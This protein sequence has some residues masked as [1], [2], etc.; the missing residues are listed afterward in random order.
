MT[1]LILTQV[2]IYQLDVP[3]EKMEVGRFGNL[4]HQFHLRILKSVTFLAVNE[5]ITCG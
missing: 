5:N 1:C 4:L 2:V 3:F